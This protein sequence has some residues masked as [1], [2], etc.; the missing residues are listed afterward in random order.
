MIFLLEKKSVLKN[1]S[2]I[3]RFLKQKQWLMQRMCLWEPAGSGWQVQRYP[4][5]KGGWT[6]SCRGSM[7]LLLFPPVLCWNDAVHSTALQAWDDTVFP[8]LYCGKLERKCWSSF[9]PKHEGGKKK[10]RKNSAFCQHSS[11]CGSIKN[12]WKI[13]PTLPRKQSKQKCR[14]L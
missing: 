7:V 5:W 1:S 10:H 9:L 8:R 2:W 13:L 11:A 4:C 3:L 6:L 12:K 14:L